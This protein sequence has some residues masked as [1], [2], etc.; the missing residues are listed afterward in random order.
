[1]FRP[2]RRAVPRQQP[3]S[4][5]IRVA[6]SHSVTGNVP[7][8]SPSRVTWCNLAAKVQSS[9]C[10]MPPHRRKGSRTELRS[11]FLHA[12]HRS[13]SLIPVPLLSER[14]MIFA[15]SLHG[16]QFLIE[17]ALSCR[18]HAVPYIPPGDCYEL[19]SGLVQLD[20]PG[21]YISRTRQITAVPHHRTF[22]GQEVCVP[23]RVQQSPY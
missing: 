23:M 20:D 2:F 18:L 22:A 6:D 14:C 10:V 9:T 17:G 19:H 7:G 13:G 8:N 16:F 3:C 12:M 1:M 21:P 15:T 5:S 11:Y 4:P